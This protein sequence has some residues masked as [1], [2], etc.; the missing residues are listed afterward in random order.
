MEV[1][2]L[3]KMRELDTVGVQGIYY[4]PEGGP[5]DVPPEGVAFLLSGG[6]AAIFTSATDWTLQV[7]SETW[8]VLPSWCFPPEDWEFRPI[9]GVTPEGELR[10][11]G[12]IE[13][14]VNSV[15]EVAGVMIAYEGYVFE[16]ASGE[17]FSV[18]RVPL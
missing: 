11:A 6:Q 13:K 18:L 5:G 8:D 4:I 16:V 7:Q 12:E 2:I 17:P 15:G 1:Q 3:D 10:R 9:P 14:R